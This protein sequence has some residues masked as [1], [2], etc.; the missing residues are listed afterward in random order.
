LEL[1]GYLINDGYAD[2]VQHVGDYFNTVCVFLLGFHQH[3]KWS[4]IHHV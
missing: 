4:S 1:Q 2:L 3:N